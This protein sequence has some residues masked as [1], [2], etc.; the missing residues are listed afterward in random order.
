M[1]IHIPPVA[2]SRT[3][4]ERNDRAWLT[5]LTE[6]GGVKGRGPAA[7]VARLLRDANGE[8]SFPLEPS[9]RLNAVS[10]LHPRME[11]ISSGDPRESKKGKKGAGASGKAAAGAS[12]NSSSASTSGGAV[13]RISKEASASS[14]SSTGSAAS[15]VVVSIYKRCW[16]TASIGIVSPPGLAVPLPGDLPKGP[17]RAQLLATLQR[18]V[19]QGGVPVAYR[20]I[21]WWELS[22][23]HAK[24]A[25]HPPGYYQSLLATP[26]TA[27]AAYAISKDL[28]RT[29]PGHAFFESKAGV[30][31]LQRLLSAFSVHNPDIGYCQSLNF[32]AGECY[33]W[34]CIFYCESVHTVNVPLEA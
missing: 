25:L 32:V 34:R 2:A 23:G 17:M 1:H 9:V 3:A 29:F 7:G 15:A 28:D 12:S 30:A 20:P 26:P 10:P 14:I 33:M 19:L 6:L 31:S 22:G 4:T 8:V 21:V 5:F 13:R 18:L 16:S 27:E 11:G 24:A